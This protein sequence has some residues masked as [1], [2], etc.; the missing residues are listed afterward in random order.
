MPRNDPIGAHGNTH[1]A[2]D[3]TALLAL[4]VSVIAL[5]LTKG[6][7]ALMTIAGFLGSYFQHAAFFFQ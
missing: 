7:I 1:D 5:I 6:P 4:F 2:L 3:Q